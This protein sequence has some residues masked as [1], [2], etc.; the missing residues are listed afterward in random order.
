MIYPAPPLAFF[1][2]G[3]GYNDPIAMATVVFGGGAIDDGNWPGDRVD[4]EAADPDVDFDSLETVPAEHMVIFE[5]NKPSSLGDYPVRRCAASG[6][7]GAVHAMVNVDG[8]WYLR[9]YA[10]DSRSRKRY[11]PRN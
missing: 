7:W 6:Y 2:G 9:R 5:E 11:P 3:E 1:M 4:T 8:Q 10:P